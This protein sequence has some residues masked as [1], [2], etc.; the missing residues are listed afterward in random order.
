MGELGEIGSY[1]KLDLLQDRF[2]NATTKLVAI[3]GGRE[4]ERVR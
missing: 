3:K 2:K 4:R 1:L